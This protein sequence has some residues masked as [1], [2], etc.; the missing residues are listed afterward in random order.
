M[1]ALRDASLHAVRDEPRARHVVTENQRVLQFADAL[2]AGDTA[3]LGA[4]MLASHASLRDDYAVSTPELDLAVDLLVEHGA[5]GARLTG[6]GFGGCV[7]ALV[8][9]AQVR[10]V[11]SKTV[12]RY[13]AETGLDADAFEVHGVDGAGRLT[14]PVGA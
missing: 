8:P 10:A 14:A 9:R 13:R 7:V 4:L 6:A 3:A 11:A 2:R 12:A 5:A 1:P